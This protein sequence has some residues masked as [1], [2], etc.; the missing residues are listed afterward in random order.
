MI[1]TAEIHVSGKGLS[2]I[3]R[4]LLPHAPTKVRVLICLSVHSLTLVHPGAIST[5]SPSAHLFA[6]S[7]LMH[8][9]HSPSNI[10]FINV[11]QLGN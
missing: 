10:C 1:K 3:R 7:M 8:K 11:V 5:T 9:L 6:T 2:A 4:L